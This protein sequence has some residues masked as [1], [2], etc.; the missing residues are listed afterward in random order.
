M[1]LASASLAQVHAA[2]TYDGQKLAVKVCI[3]KYPLRSGSCFLNRSRM[4]NF[5]GI[6]TAT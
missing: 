4:P 6:S 3:F 1:P 2:K 5:H